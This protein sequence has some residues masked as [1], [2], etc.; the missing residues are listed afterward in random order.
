MVELTSKDELLVCFYILLK[1]I[2]VELFLS[3]ENKLK[4][5]AQMELTIDVIN[6][7]RIQE[8]IKSINKENITQKPSP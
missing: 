5:F 3:A 6:S 8:L 2:L 1:Y 7:P 4:L